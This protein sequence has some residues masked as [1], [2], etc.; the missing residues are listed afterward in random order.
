MEVPD[1]VKTHIVMRTVWSVRQLELYVHRHDA[2]PQRLRLSEL[3]VRLGKRHCSEDQYKERLTVVATYLFEAGH[4][5]TAADIIYE[6]ISNPED[7]HA[8]PPIDPELR[9]WSAEEW[10]IADALDHL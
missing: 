8:L 3:R 2:E 5:R 1:F 4:Q 9:H 7:H 10:S 6:R